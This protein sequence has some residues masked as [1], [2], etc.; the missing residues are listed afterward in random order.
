MTRF[1]ENLFKKNLGTLESLR[2]AQLWMLKEGVTRG[3]VRADEGEEKPRRSPPF[4]WAAFSL[5]GDWR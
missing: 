2:E 5:S 4:Y 1:Y 3:M